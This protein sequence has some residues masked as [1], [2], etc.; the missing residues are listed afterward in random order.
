MID[1]MIDK[2][3]GVG[4]S[5]LLLIVFTLIALTPLEVFAPQEKQPFWCRARGI[6]FGLLF[7]PATIATILALL[8]SRAQVTP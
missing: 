5:E 4:R 8:C 1:A 3:I 2:A 6:L 7:I